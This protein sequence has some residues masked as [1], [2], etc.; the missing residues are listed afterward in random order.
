MTITVAPYSGHASVYP[1]SDGAAPT[2]RPTEIGDVGSVSGIHGVPDAAAGQLTGAPVSTA[3][4]LAPPNVAVD[5]ILE[6]LQ[7]LLPLFFSKGDEVTQQALSELIKSNTLVNDEL[8]KARIGKIREAA[9]QLSSAD[10]KD[11]WRSVL[12]IA[13]KALL[14][15]GAI[16][17]TVASAG[18]LGPI[19]LPLAI[20][21]IVTSVRGL[22]ND[23]MK[24]MGYPNGMGFDLTLG[25]LVKFIAQ[26]AGASEEAANEM[27]KWTDIVVGAAIAVVSVGAMFKAGASLLKVGDSAAS[28]AVS[29]FGNVATKLNAATQMAGG[30]ATMGAALVGMDAAKDRRDAEKTRAE[31]QALQADILKGQQMAQMYYDTLQSIL[32]RATDGQ[33]RLSEIINSHG[34]TQKAVQANMV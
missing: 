1:N 17:A 30:A 5:D 10:N 23:I 11:F 19:L 34:Q 27:M 26:K 12:S 21:S 2:G 18:T 32:Q 24:E 28:L 9:A 33:E 7:S 6:N 8:C 4:Q 29:K 25:N 13:G 15:V 3:P 16:V 20:Y 31:N 22:V 14:A